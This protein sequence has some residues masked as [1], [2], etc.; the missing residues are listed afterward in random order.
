MAIISRTRCQVGSYLFAGEKDETGGPTTVHPAA[1]V[2]C[3]VSILVAGGIG[4]VTVDHVLHGVG[5]KD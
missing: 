1:T 5:V 2:F 3:R 4:S